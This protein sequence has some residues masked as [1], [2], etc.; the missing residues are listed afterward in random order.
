MQNCGYQRLK[1]A[2]IRQICH[3]REI[4]EQLLKLQKMEK[5]DP[6][7][8]HQDKITFLSKF[9]CE[10]SA[11][12]DDQKAE[13]GELLV[14]FSD[15]F[16]KHRFDVGYNTG[17]KIKLTPERSKPIYGQGPPTPI[18]LRIELQVELALV[19]YYGLITTLS[20]SRYSIPLLAQRKNS[21]RLTVN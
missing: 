9:P 2:L 20:Q 21:G 17:L 3:Q 18:H 4:F 12:N 13:V 5:L 16:A 19:H 14:E 10:K 6:K 15:I 8:N 11:P 1:R 7:G